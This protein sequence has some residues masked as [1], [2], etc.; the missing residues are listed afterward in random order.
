MAPMIGESWS[1]AESHTFAELL[2]DCEEDRTLRA[3]L[4]RM[5]RETNQTWRREEPSPTDAGLGGRLD[6]RLVE[7]GCRTDP[8]A[9]ALRD[10]VA[11]TPQYSRLRIATDYYAELLQSRCCVLDRCADGAVGLRPKG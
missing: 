1:F 7:P 10:R 6:C 2:I 8:S 11:R 4:V 9:P 3:V 5:L